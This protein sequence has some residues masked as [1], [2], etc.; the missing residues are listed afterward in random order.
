M[1][2]FFVWAREAIAE[3][4][5]RVDEIEGTYIYDNYF[6]EQIGNITARLESVESA[7]PQVVQSI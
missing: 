7:A 1:S 3:L 5:Q 4:T 6:D 2:G